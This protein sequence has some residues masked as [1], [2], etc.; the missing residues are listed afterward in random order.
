MK[1]WALLLVALPAWSRKDSCV[2]CH[3]VLEGR[4]Q[5]PAS[6]FANDVHSRRGF[7]CADC[8]GGDRNAD[9]QEAAMS[10]S[11]GFRG[12][13]A[14]TAVPSLCAHCH[15]DANLIQRFKPQ[16]RVDQLAQYQTSVHGKRLAAGDVAVANCVDCHSVHDI[17]EVKDPLSPVHPLRL[18]ETC[19][20]CHADPAHMA[21]YKL[22]TNQFAEYRRSVHWDALAK[23]GDLS[24]PSCASCHGNHGATPPQVASVSAVCGTCHALFE[25]LYNKSPHQPVFRA[26]G[27]GGCVVCH[28]NHAVLKPS[29]EMLAGTRAVCASCHDST[30]QGGRV[31]EQMAALITSLSAALGRSEDILGRASRSGMEVSEAAL[32]QQEARAALVKTRAAVHAF[33]LAAVQ[34]P[35]QEGLAIAAETYRAGESALR[36]RDRRR[37][38]LAIALIAI[39]V[40]MAGLWLALRLIER[41]GQPSPGLPR[42]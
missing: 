33:Q 42:R 8:H 28:S 17:R 2:E 29:T 12:K 24:A 1:L 39:V 13:I 32:R 9:D 35:A 25:D 18:P 5:A 16:Q 34:K 6:A 4:L 38:G 40:T 37:L 23:R 7:G 14:L 26:M 11:R 10:R 30:S 27:K 41:P 3:A 36:E 20:R 21:K 15:S 19:A 31:A 22:P